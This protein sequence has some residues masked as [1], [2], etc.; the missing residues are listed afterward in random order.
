MYVERIEPIAAAVPFLTQLQRVAAGSAP[1]F[2]G[3]LGDSPAMMEVERLVE[4]IG[5]T[6]LSVLILG[7]T[8]TGKELTAKAIHDLSLRAARPLVAT[9][10]SAMAEGLLEAELFGCKKG[11]FT[12]AVA[13]REGRI[14]AASGSTL[15]LDEVGDMPLAMQ[16]AL[17]RVLQEREV[18]R[19]GENCPRP[20]DIR[21][22]AATNKDL[23][24]EVAAGRFREDLLFRVREIVVAMPPLRARGDDV[25]VLA[26]SFL[27]ECESQLALPV[28]SVSPAAERALREHAWPGNVRE[29]RS[30]MRRAAVLCDGLELRPEHLELPCAAAVEPPDS[31]EAPVATV[32]GGCP[33]VASRCPPAALGDLNRTLADARDDF[34][35]RFIEAVL[36]RHGGNRESAAAALKISVRSLYRHLSRPAERRCLEVIGAATAGRGRTE[37]RIRISGRG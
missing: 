14:E 31:V 3:L 27:R 30:T 8:G 16:A 34:V 35:S 23:D 20:V 9:N 24:A 5:P 4:R 11:A 26:R 29:L 21:L 25:L 37:T 28:H 19:L 17:L 7:E 2:A 6:D 13:D 12:G 10:C 22:V 1:A 33:E 15:F 18:V 32:D 36:E